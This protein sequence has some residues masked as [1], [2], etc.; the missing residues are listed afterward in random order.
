M[1][2]M[3]DLLY[4]DGGVPLRGEIQV[5]GAKNFVSKAMVASLLGETTAETKIALKSLQESLRN[6]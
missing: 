2:Q 6:E 5:R 1:S 4:V 3:S